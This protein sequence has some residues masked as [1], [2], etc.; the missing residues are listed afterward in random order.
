MQMDQSGAGTDNWW[1]IYK[2]F[3]L[4]DEVG[5]LG[6]FVVAIFLA[7]GLAKAGVKQIMDRVW[8]E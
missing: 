7:Y 4:L 6:I 8:I 1:L 3:F 5:K 2:W